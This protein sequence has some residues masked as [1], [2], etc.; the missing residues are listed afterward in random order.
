M[1]EYLSFSI[2]RIFWGRCLS[3]WGEEGHPHLNTLHWLPIRERIN[4]KICMHVFKC[5]HGNAPKYLPD[6]I[7]HRLGPV[8]GPI[9][10]SS[11]DSTL[12]VAHVGQNCIGDKS[13][14]VT[15]P[16]LWNALPRNIREAKLL[17]SKRC[18]SLAFIQNTDLLCVYI[19]LC[20]ST[21]AL[22]SRW[23]GAL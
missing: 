18:W 19:L 22:W 7:S 13:F 6:F 20:F 11:N 8:T 15:A 5:I 12:I 1:W 23:K 14:C 21:L 9:T 4:F 10:R 2:F 3:E 17:C 16:R